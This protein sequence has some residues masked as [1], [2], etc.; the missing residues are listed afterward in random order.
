MVPVYG[1]HQA[2]GVPLCSCGGFL[3]LPLNVAISLCVV[4]IACF[5]S[6]LPIVRVGEHT[7]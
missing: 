7:K 1:Q 4:C 5:M 6:T 3:S 2:T